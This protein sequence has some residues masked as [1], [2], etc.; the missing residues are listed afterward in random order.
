M[1]REAMH[2]HVLGRG[3][4]HYRTIRH[5]LVQTLRRRGRRPGQ[6]RQAPRQKE[7]HLLALRRISHRLVPLARAHRS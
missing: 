3:V 7:T 2:Q 4:K 1:P 5:R 6:Q